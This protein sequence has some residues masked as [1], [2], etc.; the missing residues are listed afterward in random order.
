[1]NPLRTALL[2]GLLAVLAAG[3]ATGLE[4]REDQDDLTREW[5]AFRRAQIASVAYELDF[6][7]R[8]NAETFDGVANL[9]VTL[10]DVRAP[11]SI[12]LDAK[13]LHSVT[14][15]GVSVEHLV[16]R[17][18]SFDIPAEYLSAA[19]MA[20]TITYTGAY[21]ESRNG[22]CHYTDPVDNHEY[23]HTNLEPYGAHYVFPCFNQP[24]LKAEFTA[25]VTAPAA[26]AAIGNMP[27]ASSDGNGPIRTTRF[28]T[29][30]AISPYLFFLGAGEYQV[31]HD[32]HNGLP[33]GIY[34]RA[35]MA[36][37]LDAGRLFAETRAGLDYFNAYF[38]TP[39]PFAKYDHV[40][41]PELGPGAMENP[42]AVTMNEYMIFRGAPTNED[43]RNRNNTLLHEMAHMWFGD[44]VTMAWWND[45][46]LNESFATFSAYQAQ[47]AIG[48]YDGI[49]QR[50]YQTKGWAYY[51]DQLSTT[52]PIEVAVPSAQ[53]ATAN[54]DG[55]TYA[56]GA[57]ALKQLWFTVGAE[58]YRSGVANYFRRYA[59]KNATRKQFM[60]AI[61]A[62]TD[63]NLDTW[64]KRWL[65]TEGLASMAV[66]FTC[67]NGAIANFQ[68]HQESVNAPALSPHRTQIA[69]FHFNGA[70]KLAPVEIVPT[71][72]HDGETPLEALR[73]KPCPDFVYANFGDM[74]Y[75]LYFLDSRSY[76]T[77]LEHLPALEDPFMRRMVWGTLSAMIR[78]QKLRASAFMD[79]LLK[80]LPKESDPDMLAYLLGQTP[81]REVFLRF[82]A[83]ESA[84]R[85]APR[86]DRMLWDGL[87]AAAPG[88]D[89]RL[90]WLDAYVGAAALEPSI[91][92][93]RSLLESTPGQPPLDQ[94]RRWQVIRRMASLGA[95]DTE[96]LVQAELKRDRTDQGERYAFSARGAVPAYEVKKAQ[97]ERLKDPKLS[98]S[99]L[100]SGAGSFHSELH[101]EL[102]AAFAGD[103]FNYVL[104]QN[105]ESEQHRISLWFDEL[106][107]KVYT[108][109]FLARSREALERAALPARARRA[110][111]EANDDIER[112]TAI[113][114]YDATDAGPPAN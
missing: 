7:L 86:L 11:L 59:W 111:Q 40:F 25:S 108:P 114:Q 99:L 21:S 34:A 5:A 1:M 8:E 77:I 32:G 18:G 68:I 78:Q 88:T 42:G 69:L 106:M 100:R 84:R 64:T 81:S 74:D 113:R 26:W 79:V 97:W 3:A 51:Q 87:Q 71:A 103:W 10:N 37:Y 43:Y 105:W 2:T 52:H 91:P 48:A 82:L 6:T 93:L 35:S 17:K 22:L 92:R 16:R 89:T 61:S 31:W 19:P 67:E 104:S 70:G 56:K 65:Q 107:P 102:T 83:P 101:P 15:D 110:W 62:E 50:F 95:P 9:R 13:V 90:F 85:Y 36:Q 20:I 57:S 44:L 55:I 23:L 30:P 46:W 54:F 72:F 24:D 98:L 12:D 14:L 63:L 33:L 38:G 60:D 75:G 4:P 112:I 53:L 41:A 73:G 49:W 109:E 28:Q 29:T 96:A 47:E 58:A 80:N 39:Y 76:T 94:P 27:P 45:L 66:E